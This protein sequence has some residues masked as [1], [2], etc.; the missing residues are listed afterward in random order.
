[1]KRLSFL[2]FVTPLLFGFGF[3]QTQPSSGPA[4]T[5]TIIGC[6]QPAER[7][8]SLGGTVLGTSATPDTAPVDAN[9]SEPAPGYVLSDARLGANA[10]DDQNASATA[11]PTTGVRGPAATSSDDLDR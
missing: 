11:A 8:G 3:T 1:M 4:G 5:L 2:L 10:T 7:S 6:L 9:L